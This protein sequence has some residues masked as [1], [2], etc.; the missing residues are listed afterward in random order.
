[1]LN[2]NTETKIT[3]KPI[4]AR[5]LVKPVAPTEKIGSLF[6]P[7]TAKEKPQECIVTELGTGRLK[8]DGTR[9]PFDVK[10]GDRVIVG[11]YAGSEIRLDGEDYRLVDCDDVMGTLAGKGLVGI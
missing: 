2:V 4:G 8:D 3:L 10:V 7:D 6:I 1:M 9:V 11:K 5:M